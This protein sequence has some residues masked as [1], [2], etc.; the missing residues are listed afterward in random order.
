MTDLK[1]SDPSLHYTVQ[2]AGPAVVLLPGLLSDSASWGPLVPQLANHHHVICPDPRHTGRSQADSSPVTIDT[3]C[4]DIIAL[5]DRLA[6]PSFSLVGHSFGAILAHHVA[7][8][9]PERVTHLLC[10][11]AAPSP[12]TRLAIIFQ[13][14]VEV[15]ICGCTRCFLGCFTGKPLRHQTR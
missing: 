8:R 9:M 1:R 7:E 6:L 11:A 4:A 14:L 10:M 3:L 12:D 13:T 2:G 15:R 5:V